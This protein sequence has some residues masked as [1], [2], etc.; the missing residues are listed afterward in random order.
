L[1]GKTYAAAVRPA[2]PVPTGDDVAL[3][4]AETESKALGRALMT[5]TGMK[6][7]AHRNRIITE[8]WPLGNDS[9][10]PDSRALFEPRAIRDI[11]TWLM[12]L[13]D[14]LEVAP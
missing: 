4:N 5:L 7:P 3:L 10:P 9:V 13:A 6:V 2:K 8:W 12:Q 11:A 1:D 14:D